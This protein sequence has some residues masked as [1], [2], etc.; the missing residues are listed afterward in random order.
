MLKNYLKIAFRQLTRHK[1][2][3]L[4]NIFCLGT[5]ITFSIIIGMYIL[6]QRQ[7]N[8]PLKNLGRQYLIKSNWKVKEMGWDITTLGPLAK[9]IKEEYP[10]LVENYYRYNPVANVVTVGNNHFKENVAIGDTTLVSMY[11]FPVLYGDKEKAFTNI[12]S[13]VIT[14]S[15]AQQL[16]SVKNAIGKTFSLTTTVNDEKQQYM[17]TAVLKDIPPNSVTG[18]I[19]TD[20]NIFIPTTGSRYYS[21]A[22]GADPSSGWNSVYEIGMLELKPG[23]DPAAL[24]L[25]FKQVL[26][27]MRIRPHRTI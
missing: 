16:F 23:V 21:N 22:A 17:V 7:V 19:N 20:Y 13:A 6:N 27:N 1:L 11:G 9:T 12:N 2:F 18:L 4:I 10:A 24:T 15:V 26:K 3:S 5:G 14:E 8:D 25:P